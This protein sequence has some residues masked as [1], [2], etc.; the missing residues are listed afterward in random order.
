[1]SGLGISDIVMGLAVKRAGASAVSA[2]ASRFCGMS[3]W[4]V[5]PRYRQP[6]FAAS[7]RR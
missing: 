6:F 7:I 3:Q 2:I 5:T 1:M 4:M